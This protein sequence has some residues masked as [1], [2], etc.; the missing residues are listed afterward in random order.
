[1]ENTQIV[2]PYFK[3]CSEGMANIHYSESN[4]PRGLMICAIGDH[5]RMN[6]SNIGTL[7]QMQSLGCD[8][9]TLV[10][11]VGSLSRDGEALTH[12]VRLEADS[13]DLHDTNKDERSSQPRN[14]IGRRG[15]TW[16]LSGIVGFGIGDV[17]IEL[18]TFPLLS[19][20]Q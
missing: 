18:I 12:I 8:L 6:N 14:P 15:M 11:S 10:R 19:E 7:T 16:I 3:L 1:M 17:S 13:E 4:M 5:I 20:S 2:Q 9:S